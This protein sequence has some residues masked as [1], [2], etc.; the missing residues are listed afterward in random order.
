M[1]GKSNAAAAVGSTRS[2]GAHSNAGD[3]GSDDDDALPGPAW[4]CDTD[5]ESESENAVDVGGGRKQKRRKKTN[6][7]LSQRV[8][9]AFA[10]DHDV[11][12]IDSDFA[13]HVDIRC[14]SCSMLGHATHTSDA[15]VS[16]EA[17]AFRAALTLSEQAA[18]PRSAASGSAHPNAGRVARAFVGKDAKNTARRVARRKGTVAREY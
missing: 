10:R 16:E 18:Q 11:L 2:S 4:L 1:G 14:A 17:Q 3:D 7:E 13:A 15:C 9:L 8:P 12:V 5:T 6:K